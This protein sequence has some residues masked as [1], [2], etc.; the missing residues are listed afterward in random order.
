MNLK[1]AK[2]SV[3]NLSAVMKVEK[4]AY[5][6]PWSREFVKSELK[7]A[8]TKAL[9]IRHEGELA[10]FCLFHEARSLGRILN[11]A[12]HPKF[13]GKKLGK[14]LLYAA[15]ERLKASGDREV[16]LEVGTDNRVALKLYE[17]AGFRLLRTFEDYYGDGKDAYQLCAAF[18]EGHPH[19]LLPWKPPWPVEGFAAPLREKPAKGIGLGV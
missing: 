15:L 5:D 11:L 7:F 10:G 2:L 9:G 8:A 18:Q 17:S 14:A 6:D 4:A 12:I 19:S 3:K 16:F 1:I 13:Q